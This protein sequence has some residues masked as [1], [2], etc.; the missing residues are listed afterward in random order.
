[1][2]CPTCCLAA[3]YGTHEFCCGPM[4]GVCCGKPF[5]DDAER[6]VWR[7]VPSEEPSYMKQPYVQ[8][9]NV[10]YEEK[11][12]DALLEEQVKKK[13]KK[14]KVERRKGKGEDEGKGDK[15]KKALEK[16]LKKG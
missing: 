15:E 3:D 10:K 1:M 2:C 4:H 13:E 6:I 14:V 5:E 9:Q 16:A 11:M 8:A 12:S 7:Q